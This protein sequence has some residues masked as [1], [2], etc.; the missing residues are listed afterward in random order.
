MDGRG[1]TAATWPLAAVFRDAVATPHDV[2]Q[3]AA[4]FAL[5]DTVNG[6]AMRRFDLPQPVIWWDDEDEI[7]ALAIQAEQHGTD[8]GD[9]L[10]VLGLLLPDGSTAVAMVED[11]EVVDGFDEEWIALIRVETHTV[12]DQDAAQTGEGPLLSRRWDDA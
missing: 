8:E 10:E 2:D 11:V 3:A 9:T 5:G 7:G 4:V 6:R 12:E 1:F